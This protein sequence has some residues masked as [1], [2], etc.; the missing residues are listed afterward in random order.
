MMNAV[1][2]KQGD[3]LLAG[4]WQS[5]KQKI[6]RNACPPSLCH[7]EKMIVYWKRKCKMAL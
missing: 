7:A 2:D 1:E 3:I 5:G 6:N 4:A